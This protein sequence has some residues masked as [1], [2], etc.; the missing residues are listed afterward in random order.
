MTRMIRI[1]VIALLLAPAT[2]AHAASLS[3]V[4]DP[5]AAPPLNTPDLLGVERTVDEFADKVVMINFW[6]TWCPPCVKE[7]PSMQTLWERLRQRDFV[8]LA[9]NVGEDR[10]TI[11]EF[12]ERFDTDIDFPLLIDADLEVTRGWPVFGL[13]T[14]FLLDRHG[15]IVLKA[16]GEREWT[17]PEI[18]AQILELLEVGD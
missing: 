15:R 4:E 10:S 18:E 14:T 7:L 2:A 9:V 11:I 12:L 17:D 1:M 3:V 8:M 5:S 13:P 16:L 6:A